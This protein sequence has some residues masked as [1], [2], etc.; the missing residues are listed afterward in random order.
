MY[1]WI[2]PKTDWEADDYFNS[3]DH[4]RIK[5]NFAALQAIHDIVIKDGQ[6]LNNMV[7]Y[8]YGKIFTPD[9]L[10]AVEANMMKLPDFCGDSLSPYYDR[11]EKSFTYSGKAW[12]CHD[13]NRIE[14]NML[15]GYHIVSSPLR[16]KK[17]LSFTLGGGPF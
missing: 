10:N 12:D 2:T 15:L 4:N 9:M 8:I 13:L 7:D 16:Y 5:G 3:Q 14:K 17:I 11:T 6:Q 1:G